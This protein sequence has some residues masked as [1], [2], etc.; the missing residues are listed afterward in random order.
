MR[1]MMINELFNV[2]ELALQQINESNAAK[3]ELL[4]PKAELTAQIKNELTKALNARTNF[5]SLNRHENS[6]QGIMLDKMF[7]ENV[8]TK[9]REVCALISEYWYVVFDMDELLAFY[10]D[11]DPEEYEKIIKAIGIEDSYGDHQELLD[12]LCIMPGTRHDGMNREVYDYRQIE[13][14]MIDKRQQAEFGIASLYKD[15]QEE[16]ASVV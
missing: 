4:Q 6:L 15:M 8:N 5:L 13:N 1:Y 3:R 10:R 2:G 11:K 16:I 14:D 7:S 9:Y 12:R